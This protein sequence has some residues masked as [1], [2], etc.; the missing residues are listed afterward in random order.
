MRGQQAGTS[1]GIS[2]WVAALFGASAA[3]A[4]SGAFLG[5]S[6]LQYSWLK[7]ASS[8]GLLPRDAAFAGTLPFPTQPSL[9]LYALAGVSLLAGLALHGRAS[10]PPREPRR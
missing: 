7:L 9:P 5:N 6:S 10:R 2:V 3:F 1:G 4:L 8:L